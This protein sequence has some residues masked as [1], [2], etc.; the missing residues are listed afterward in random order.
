MLQATHLHKT[1]V[2]FFKD[3][4]ARTMTTEEVT[5]AELRELIL[6]TKR[7]T[8]FALPL[9][10]MAEFGNA[11]NGNDCLRY[12]KNVKKSSG[13]EGDYDQEQIP[14]DDAVDIIR[15]AA[16]HALLYTSPSHSPSRPRCWR[17]SRRPCL[18]RD[19]RPW[20]RG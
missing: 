15:E 12:D 6:Q 20:W 19:A 11:P 5:L 1:H 2:T 4:A 13:A 17:R 14:F 8:K 10:K 3:V 16:I 9:L 18:P 7:R